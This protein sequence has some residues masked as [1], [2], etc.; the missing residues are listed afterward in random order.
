MSS[1]VTAPHANSIGSIFSPSSRTTVS[2]LDSPGTTPSRTVTRLVA[3]SVHH[4]A[5]SSR[6]L[7][8]AVFRIL[9]SAI[10]LM[11]MTMGDKLQ[12]R[13]RAAGLR[14]QS[15]VDGYFAVRLLEPVV[16]LL[17]WTF[18]REIGFF[19]VTLL[20]AGAYLI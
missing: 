17:F 8:D 1:A 5:Q 3:D 2:G 7:Q 11:G 9:H 19:V 4:S 13:F 18:F 20:A 15:S 14:A 6:K 16:V 10:G 12:T